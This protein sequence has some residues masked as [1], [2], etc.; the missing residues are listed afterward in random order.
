[1]DA[2]VWVM[3]VAPE[4]PALQYD[5]AVHERVKEREPLPQVEDHAPHERGDHAVHVPATAVGKRV[6]D[7]EKNNSYEERG[8]GRPNGWS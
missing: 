4:Q 5:A 8:K 1:M 3:M 7:K 6:R 2:F